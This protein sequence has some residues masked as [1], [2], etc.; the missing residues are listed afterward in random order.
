MFNLH[1]NHTMAIWRRIQQ[2]NTWLGCVLTEPIHLWTYALF[3]CITG[4]NAR[5][6]F[7]FYTEAKWKQYHNILIRQ[8]VNDLKAWARYGPEIIS[9]INDKYFGVLSLD[10]TLVFAYCTSDSA[11]SIEEIIVYD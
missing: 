2:N 8:G 11:R 10:L 9:S 1:W 3:A 4:F 5:S 7:L 6:S